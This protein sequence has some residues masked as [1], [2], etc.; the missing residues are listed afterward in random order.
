MI[1]P[2]LMNEGWEDF[3]NTNGRHRDTKD[4]LLAGRPT[5]DK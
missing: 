5:V 4:E 1:G 2:Y 3:R